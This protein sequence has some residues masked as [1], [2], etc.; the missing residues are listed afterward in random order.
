MATIKNHPQN[1][2]RRQRDNEE[3][4]KAQN[5]RRTELST[6]GL[7]SEQNVGRNAEISDESMTGLQSHSSPFT[8]KATH[9]GAKYPVHRGRRKKVKED[10]FDDILGSNE[11]EDHSSTNRRSSHGEDEE[12]YGTYYDRESNDGDPYDY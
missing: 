3:I 12:D 9:S 7:S 10:D 4:N 8:R 1:T 6:T 2:G 5:L 11:E